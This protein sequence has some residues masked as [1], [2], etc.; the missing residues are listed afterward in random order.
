[1]L[2]SDRAFLIGMVISVSPVLAPHLRGQSRY[3]PTARGLVQPLTVVCSCVLP[4]PACVTAQSCGT[5]SAIVPAIR[6]RFLVL[7]WT[8]LLSL[9]VQRVREHSILCDPFELA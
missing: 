9:P 3:A 2:I 7:T 5:L 6:Y 8:L 1:M 4:P